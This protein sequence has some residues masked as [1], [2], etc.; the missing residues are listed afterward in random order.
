MLR[1]RKIEF[2]H[3]MGDTLYACAPAHAGDPRPHRALI[4]QLGGIHGLRDTPM[5]IHELVHVGTLY[6]RHHG[7]R[8]RLD[9]VIHLSKQ[10]N[11]EVAGISRHQERQDLPRPAGQDLVAAGPSF[12]HHKHGTRSIALADEVV[13]GRNLAGIGSGL[14]KER[15]FLA[16]QRSEATKLAYEGAV[17]L[18]NSHK[19]APF[20]ID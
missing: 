15:H 7:R 11:V 20:H 19:Q 5:A 18:P 2:A 16:G 6:R 3:Q 9:A 1:A 14:A 12:Q 13:S 17:H 8:D 4:D 10:S